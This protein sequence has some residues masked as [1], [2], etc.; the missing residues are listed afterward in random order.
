MKKYKRSKVLE[1]RTNEKRLE[2]CCDELKELFKDCPFE[3][4]LGRLI[5]GAWD[6]GWYVSDGATIYRIPEDWPPEEQIEDEDT[7]TLKRDKE[8]GLPILEP[9]EMEVSDD[10]HGSWHT[11]QVYGID[12]ESSFPIVGIHASWAEARPIQKRQTITIEVTEEQKREIEAILE[13]NS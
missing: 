2:D 7:I 13:G 12:K 6:T 1:A 5:G 10:G 8:T 11:T 3:K 4:T 9:V